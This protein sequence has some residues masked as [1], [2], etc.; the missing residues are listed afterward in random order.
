MVV[1]YMVESDGGQ[2]CSQ[3]WCWPVIWSALVLANHM[4]SAGASQLYDSGLVLR[5][6]L[7]GG[8]E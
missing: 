4:V 6:Y 7:F 3:G 1:S 2:S 8:I 5:F